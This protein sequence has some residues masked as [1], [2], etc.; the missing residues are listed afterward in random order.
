MNVDEPLNTFEQHICE[1]HISKLPEK[2][3]KYYMIIDVGCH[4][5]NAYCATFP[6]NQFDFVIYFLHY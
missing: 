4:M 3:Y 1:C 2:N 5:C 6:N